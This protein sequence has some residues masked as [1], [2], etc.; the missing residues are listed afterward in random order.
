[1]YRFF[2]MILVFCLEVFCGLKVEMWSLSEVGLGVVGGRN[3]WVEYKRVGSYVVK[4]FYIMFRVFISLWVNLKLYLCRVG[5]FGV[6]E[7][8][9]LGS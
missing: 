7:R 1:M 9:V 2:L 5:F 6:W 3:L 8:V 4:E